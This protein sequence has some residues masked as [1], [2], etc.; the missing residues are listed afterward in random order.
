MTEFW[1][2]INV[3]FPHKDAKK[4]GKDKFHDMGDVIEEIYCDIN[5][6][7]KEKWIKMETEKEL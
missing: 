6:R 1:N 5:S 2:L 3:Y 4:E 7:L